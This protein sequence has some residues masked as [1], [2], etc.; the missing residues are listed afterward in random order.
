MIVEL[1]K[2]MLRFSLFETITFTLTQL[3]VIIYIQQMKMAKE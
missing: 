1:T 2:R 3:I